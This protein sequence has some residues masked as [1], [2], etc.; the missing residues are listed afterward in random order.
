VIDSRERV[1]E[2]SVKEGGEGDEWGRV[3]QKG[4]VKWNMNSQRVMLMV[5]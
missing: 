1:G 2:L 5:G 4:K 3:E